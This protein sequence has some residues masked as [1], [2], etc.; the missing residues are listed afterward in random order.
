LKHAIERAVLL[1]N[2]KTID[3]DDLELTS[4]TV[5]LSRPNDDAVN[6]DKRP[7]VSNP[8]ITISL[9]LADASLSRVEKELVREVLKR[10]RGNKKRAAGILKI[11]RPRLDRLINDDPEFF[12]SVT[13]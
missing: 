2:S 11:S 9:L 5:S 8:D 6:T 7:Q 10:M 1:S 13:G 4:K 3:E 12:E